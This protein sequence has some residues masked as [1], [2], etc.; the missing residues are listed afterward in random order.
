MSDGFKRKALT[1][2]MWAD[3]KETWGDVPVATVADLAALEAIA[4][5]DWAT[6]VPPTG[7]LT[8]AQVVQAVEEGAPT[9]DEV[10]DA[11]ID[12]IAS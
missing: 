11:V 6:V 5:P 8:Y 1:G 7:G 10:A 4:G 12:E 3:F 2:A 9:A